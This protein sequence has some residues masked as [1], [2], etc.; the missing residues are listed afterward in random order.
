MRVMSKSS[1]ALHVRVPGPLVGLLALAG[2]AGCSSSPPSVR[3]CTSA[4]G[5]TCMEF[6]GSAWTESQTRDFCAPAGSTPGTLAMGRCSASPYGTCILGEGT[7]SEIRAYV[8]GAG[9]T[10]AFIQST[11]CSGAGPTGLGVVWVSGSTGARTTCTS[12]DAGVDTDA[13]QPCTTSAECMASEV[14]VDR[15][16]AA[17]PDGG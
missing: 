2:L 17:V 3:T 7:V 11:C 9:V 8:Y 15:R 16:C 5:T 13:G 6:T 14:C 4:T 10:E 12:P 1:R